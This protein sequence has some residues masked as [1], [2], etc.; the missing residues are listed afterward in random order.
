M[1][2]ADDERTEE[3]DKVL[4]RIAEILS[5]N[6]FSF[7]TNVYINTSQTFSGNIQICRTDK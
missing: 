6:A 5:E 4:S 1:Q 3:A 2:L 7:S